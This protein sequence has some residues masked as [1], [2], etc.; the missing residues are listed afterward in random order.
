MDDYNREHIIAFVLPIYTLITLS[1][2]IAAI[3]NVFRKL[4]FYRFNALKQGYTSIMLDWNF[5][6]VN[7]TLF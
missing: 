1:S 7:T 5:V 4:L 6:S 2:I 3:L